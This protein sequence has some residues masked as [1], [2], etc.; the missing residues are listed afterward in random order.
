MPYRLKRKESVARAVRRI[1]AEQVDRAIAELTDPRMDR[2][3]AVHQARKRFKKIRA[4]LRLVRPAL[5]KTYAA[6]NAW[7]RDAGGRLAAARDAAVMVETLDALIA[8]SREKSARSLA[9][10]RRRLV[11]RRDAP[12]ASTTVTAAD[13]ERM[14][15]DLAGAKTRIAAWRLSSRGFAAVGPGLSK[16]YARGRGALARVAR[17]PTDENLHDLRKRIRYLQYHVRLLRNASPTAMDGMGT[18]LHDLADLL[19]ADHDLAVLE[20]TVRAAPAKFGPRRQVRALLDLAA[21]RRKALLDEA[22]PLAR[23]AYAEKP[24]RFVGRVE[25][26]WKAWRRKGRNNGRME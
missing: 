13:A 18:A 16:T 6:E 21:A 12:A 17:N 1:A 22:L 9:A 20:A 2:D 26:C 4:L 8:A 11:A 15:A 3:T 25:A 23:R 5:G 7:F 24:G 10:V 14:A 19:G